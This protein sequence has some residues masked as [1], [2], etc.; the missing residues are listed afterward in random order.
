MSALLISFLQGISTEYSLNVVD[1][2][3]KTLNLS[4]ITKLPIIY[5]SIITLHYDQNQLVQLLAH[6]VL[7]ETKIAKLS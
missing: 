7:L 3:K 1:S 4:N 6:F 2:K 5:S